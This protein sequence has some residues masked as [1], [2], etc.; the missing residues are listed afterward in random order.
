MKASLSTVKPRRPIEYF[1]NRVSS[2]GFKSAS[3]FE[4][5][6]DRVCQVVT[7]D[8]GRRE[9]SSPSHSRAP[10]AMNALK[11]KAKAAAEAVAAKA[12]AASEVAIEKAR[13]ETVR[14]PADACRARH[15]ASPRANTRGVTRLAR[16]AS[17]PDPH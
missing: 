16:R 12:S 15:R 3:T 13:K 4:T 1:E 8:T 7:F 11:E 6:F 14:L 5:R 10:H 17:R 2:L 9:L